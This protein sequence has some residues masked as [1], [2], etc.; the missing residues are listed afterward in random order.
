[1]VKNECGKT[2][3]I[4]NPYE[5]WNGENGF[6]WRVLKKYQNPE[7]EIRNEYAR[8]F[9]AVKS[10][11][12][13][14]EFEMGDVYRREIRMYGVKTYQDESIKHQAEDYLI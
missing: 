11:F 13:Y 5:I 3:K 1:M 4:D 10:P 8:W 12:T 6:E 14:G 9:C 2:R 7:N